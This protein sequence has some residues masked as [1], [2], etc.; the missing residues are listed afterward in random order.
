MKKIL[1]YLLFANSAIFAQDVV[2][3]GKINKTPKI[4][5]VSTTGNNSNSGLTTSLSFATLTFAVSYA[6]PI[7]P[8]DYI[9]VKAG[10]YGAENVLFQ[11]SGTANDPIYIIGYKNIPGS[12]T[13]PSDQPPL[14]VDATDPY[15]AYITSDMPTFNGSN[16][17]TGIG[18]DMRNSEN[19]VLRNF[20]IEQYVIGVILGNE[21]TLTAT[22]ISLYNIGCKTIGSTSAAYSGQ[23]ILCG[24]LENNFSNYSTIEKCQVVNCCAELIQVCGNYNNVKD[25]KIFCNEN[26]SNA[27]SDY[28]LTIFGSYN[29][30][31]G[32]YAYRLTGLSA[33]GHGYTIKSNA[34]DVIDNPGGYNLIYPKFNEIINCTAENMGES[35]CVRHR[36]VTNNTFYKCTAIGTYAGTYL[37]SSGEGNGITIRDGAANNTFNSI[38]VKYCAS[39]IT[40]QDTSEDG[41]TG[42][43]PPGHPGSGN[44]VIN[45]IFNVCYI[46]VNF[47][48]YSIASDAGTNT[49]ANCTFYKC[50][51]IHYADRRCENMVYKNNIY[52]T[53]QGYF[54]GSTYSTDIA[55]GQ[56]VN[57][58]FYSV[59]IPGGFVTGT[60]IGSDP[61][62]T[63]AASNNFLIS[64]SSPCKNTGTNLSYIKFD[65]CGR[66]K[67]ISIAPSMGAYER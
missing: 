15:A 36:W 14:L 29:K 58:D 55:S 61:L 13:S 2:F 67:V 49:I 47:D 17:T 65:Y 44:K 37:G 6:S 56:F 33:S 66:R 42:G 53:A 23:G 21:D 30:I 60:N 57:C 19:I 35:F 50:D 7:L 43:S 34:E 45:S 32:C 38:L 4:Y 46:G 18:F 10:N 62:F 31:T 22:N 39:G 11:K 1:Y 20:Q 28:Y 63:N 27:S 26:T 64:N 48:S 59:S 40:F 8:G 54:R 25:T 12:L 16:R 24:S 9:Y 41:D 51:Y 3:A 5:Y 52:S